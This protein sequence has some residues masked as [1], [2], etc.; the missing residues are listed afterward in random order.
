MRNSF[1]D[2]VVVGINRMPDKIPV[3][4][5]VV[6]PTYNER[7]NVSRLIPAVLDMDADLQV[8]VVDDGSPDNT[9]VA[10]LDLKK[11]YSGR[12]FLESR[13]GKRGLG[14]ACVD[15]F[16]WGLA[17]GYDFLIEMDGDW[18]HHPKYLGKMLRLAKENDFIIGSRYVPDGGT[19]NWGAGRKILSKFG[20][21]YSRLIL[22][23]RIADFTG[24]FNGWSAE[25]LRK[26]RLDTVRSNGYSF[27]IELKYRAHKL[28]FRHVEFP[29]IF[30]ER[31]AGKSKM[32]VFIALEALWRVWGLRFFCN[33]I[34]EG[35]KPS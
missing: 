11:K 31:R 24:G 4:P 23:V 12:V 20:S 35:R 27:Q 32:S 25:V 16:R 18:S 8:L 13:S 33:I 19:L 15:G 5:L 9:A 28:G 30:D 7:D 26:I 3:K 2:N 34:Q 6:I 29:I 22:G 14:R 1:R 21:L 10:V 17:N